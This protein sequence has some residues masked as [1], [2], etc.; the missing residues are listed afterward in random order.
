MTT[1]EAFHKSQLVH[2]AFVASVV[3][4][5]LCGEVTNWSFAPF[6]GFGGSWIQSNE[7]WIRISLMCFAVVNVIPVLAFYIRHTY[8]D[9][10]VQRQRGRT[11]DAE[12]V[13]RAL[14]Q[15][16]MLRIAPIAAAASMGLMLFVFGGERID[17]YLFCGLS[18]SGLLLVWPRRAEWERV[19]QRCA[20]KYAD[21]PASPWLT[22]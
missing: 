12:V 6:E 9:K 11:V 18:L 1:A 7:L 21:V 19:F 16:Q 17:L 8:P 13:A 15:V 22:T 3:V 10:V 20:A 5:M 14:H 4:Y 2:A